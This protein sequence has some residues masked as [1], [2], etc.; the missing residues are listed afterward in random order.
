MHTC[1]ALEIYSKK[2]LFKYIKNSG[3]SGDSDLSF[4]E[5]KNLYKN[6][7]KTYLE[8]EVIFIKALPKF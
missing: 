5:A 3:V 2:D 1:A 4:K 7:N 6:Y 8:F